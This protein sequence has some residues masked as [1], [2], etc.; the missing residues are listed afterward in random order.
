MVTFVSLAALTMLGSLVMA[1]Q[2]PWT[3]R[4]PILYVEEWE[5]CLCQRL[6]I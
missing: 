4:D 5:V 1:T 3:T 2:M 6:P